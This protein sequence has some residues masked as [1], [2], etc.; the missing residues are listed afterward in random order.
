[1]QVTLS[2]FA[3]AVLC[4][5]PPAAALQ[6]HD[7]CGQPLATT[8]GASFDLSGASTG[9]EG[10]LA[11]I[12]SEFGSTAIE[13]D[14]W[15]LWVAP[16]DGRVDLWASGGPGADF[17]MAIHAGA[18]CPTAPP[19]ECSDDGAGVFSL[20]PWL[21][22]EVQAGAPYLIQLGVSPGT[23]PGA[24]NL[25]VA[26]DSFQPELG[27]RLD[28]T[29]SEYS[30]AHGQPGEVAWIQ[31]YTAFGGSD[32]I[33]ALWT[34]YGSPASGPGFAGSDVTAYLWEDPDDDGRLDDAQ[35]LATA[36]AQVALEATDVPLR[37]PFA[38]PVAVSGKFFVGVAASVP[39]GAWAAP[40]D[41]SWFGTRSWIAA[42][43]SGPFD[44]SCLTCNDHPPV[45]LRDALLDGVFLLRAEG[46]DGQLATY[47]E[48]WLG[49][50]VPFV[51]GAGR[52]SL[53]ASTLQVSATSVPNS[54]N[55]M[56]LWSSGAAW[57]PFRAGVQ[58]LTAPLRSTPITSS[59][60][61]PRPPDDCSG[62]LAFSWTSAYLGAQ[63]L[64]AGDVVRGQFWVRDPQNAGGAQLTR[65]LV[66]VVLP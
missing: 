61:H 55:G 21:R 54:R 5:A 36:T 31:R 56:L 47:C 51:V 14:L 58:C 12:C 63:G 38:S 8:S 45:L 44:P 40:A 9:P 29:R 50:C 15:F 7:D 43:L 4:S 35:L 49:P 26:F 39:A 27:Y 18:A 25:T 62:S 11:S 24:G 19:L 52:P 57:T 30:F 65:A 64:A 33:A 41:D 48:S 37:I 32:Q 2:L 42:N 17:K 60:G 59:G 23:S 10:Q 66:F 13:L 22:L 1:M 20:D 28:D 16:G 3:S 53:A 6:A 34:A 46:R